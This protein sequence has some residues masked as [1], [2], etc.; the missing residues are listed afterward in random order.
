MVEEYDA[1]CKDFRRTVHE[2]QDQGNLDLGEL[3]L[4]SICVCYGHRFAYLVSWDPFADIE[5]VH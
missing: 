1:F 5:P 3:C 4:Y 2:N